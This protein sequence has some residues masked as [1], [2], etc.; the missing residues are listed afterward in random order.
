MNKHIRTTL[1]ILTATIVGFALIICS[2]DS[3]GDPAGKSK[4]IYLTFDRNAVKVTKR[5]GRDV[6]T[7]KMPRCG[8]P[9]DKPGSPE[10]PACFVRV[11]VPINAKFNNVTISNFNKQK[12]PGTYNPDFVKPVCRPGQT[13]PPA[14]ASQDIYNGENTYPVQVVKFLRTGIIRGYKI[15][16][17]RVNPVQ[18]QPKTGELVLYDS[19]T[20]DIKY[21]TAKPK[22]S[23]LKPRKKS[24][25]FRKLLSRAVSNPED[26][27]GPDPGDTGGPGDPKPAEGSPEPFGPGGQIDYLI[28]CCDAFKGEFQVLAD[29]KKKKGV[30]SKIVTTESIA[31]DY[32]GEDTQE[33]IKK[34]IIDYVTNNGTV[35]VLLG[36]DIDTIP[37]RYCYGE[38]YLG[39]NNYEIDHAPTDLYYSG[40][41]D[42]YWNDDNDSYVADTTGDSIDMEPDVFVGRYSCKST[43]HVQAYVEK[44]LDY[45]KNAPASG[46]CREILLTGAELWGRS[47]GDSDA[48]IW[49]MRMY[50]DC[51]AP[52]WTP[53]KTELFDTTPGV[54]LT[55]TRLSSE[56]NLGYAFL[57]MATHG[58]VPIWS[59]ETGGNYHTDNASVQT[60]DGQ[61]G[62]VYTIACVTNGFDSWTFGDDNMNCLSEGFTR[63]PNGGA[64]GFI[65]SS[66][67]GWGV[68]SSSLGGSSF[69]YN[70]VFYEKLLGED[71]YHLGEAFAEH[72]WQLADLCGQYNSH[73]W[74]Q[75]YINLMGDPELPIWTDNP[76][77]MTVIYPPEIPTGNQTIY[78]KA[79]PNAHVCL[80]KTVDDTDEVYVFGDADASGV[81]EAIINPATEGI[82]KLTV[83]KHNFT[84]FEADIDVV[85]NA[86]LYVS[87]V[88]LPGGEVDKPYSAM[89]AATGGT[90]PYTWS[91]I[92]GSL[93]ASLT[94]Y[95]NGSITGSPDATG[96][97]TFTVQVEDS[98]YDT[99][100]RELTIDVVLDTPVIQAFP[101]PEYNGNYRVNWTSSNVPDRYELQ[102][103]SSFSNLIQDD[104][105][106]GIGQWIVD[107]FQ[108]SS[109]RY[110]S[111]ANSFFGGTGNNISHSMTYG[112]PIT[113]GGTTEL[114]F[115]TW[116]D[117]EVNYDYAYCEISTNGG[118]TWK[119][120][121]IYSG[122]GTTWTRETIDLSP[123]A[124]K[125]IQLRFRYD[126]DG[127][128]LEEGFY[129]DDIEVT[130]L[131]IYDW[132][133]LSGSIT[134]KFYDIS[135]R[136]SGGTCYYRVKAFRNLDSSGWSGIESITVSPNG[137]FVDFSVDKILAKPY[138][139]L[140]YMFRYD[141]DSPEDIGTFVIEAPV[142]EHT[143]YLADSAES[144]NSLHAG[145]VTVSYWDGAAWQDDSW[146][147]VNA[148]SVQKI[149]WT[150]SDP[151][152]MDSGAEFEGICDGPFPDTDSGE[153]VFKVKVD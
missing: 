30:P 1:V 4:K 66:R 126:T 13:A 28:V 123:Y 119:K 87:T 71:L 125:L 38:V 83:T 7:L 33:K 153:V 109:A 129:V 9:A 135:G 19:I 63:N 133:S 112:S 102:E 6:V 108:V 81:F 2:P 141:N 50:D 11:A 51:I 97:W 101:L 151:V 145:G 107:N 113:V 84:P 128:I 49:T 93:P 90:P 116:F 110:Y 127:S 68:P 53:V 148:E 44:V 94:L 139:D 21:T 5:N 85:A 14:S 34:C 79:E 111:N 22:K 132:I 47:G 95:G 24:G 146:D 140:T 32:T 149:R 12:L 99:H 106:S 147:N 150:F 137:I 31:A 74:L 100:T 144:A 75:F 27:G 120:L 96:S 58:N 124:G 143:T 130:G 35:Y 91:I 18:F 10:L 17:F 41:D 20:L 55:A 52:F 73:R 72:K 25:L 131:S 56:I 92:S 117:I 67:Y 122:D 103:S 121:K 98:L 46:F 78:V 60:N 118:S 89:L 65:G 40:L 64:V 59:M 54:N 43:A 23:I 48:E 138:E 57:N 136:A 82:L 114:S 16:F 70:R 86:L 45:E 15:F 152:G 42:I 3:F 134:D 142:P 69:D 36:G 8:Y 105:E 80:W 104:A 115:W 29:W 62:L 37:P 77:T 61:C 26:L 88:A 76:Q 39:D